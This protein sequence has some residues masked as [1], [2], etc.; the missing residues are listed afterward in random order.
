MAGYILKEEIKNEYLPK[1]I[2]FI[3]EATNDE[4]KSRIE[5]DFS[6][7]VI[8]PY[9]L[10]ELVSVLGYKTEV[11]CINDCDMDFW[12]TCTKEDAIPLGIEGCGMSFNLKLIANN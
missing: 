6:D 4:S 11:D 10:K 3:D 12:M 9:I 5:I 7:T 8:S 1:I 2:N